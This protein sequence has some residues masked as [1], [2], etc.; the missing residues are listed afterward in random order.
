MMARPSG[1]AVPPRLIVPATAGP[2]P[3]HLG[4]GR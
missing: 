2:R 1:I 3:R 4:D